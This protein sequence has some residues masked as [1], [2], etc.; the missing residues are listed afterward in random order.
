MILLASFSIQIGVFSTFG[1]LL[2]SI[3]GPFGFDTA[4]IALFG[5][6]LLASGIIC[7]PIICSIVGMT[8]RYL[9]ILRTLSC[10]LAF[11][12]WCALV[13][14]NDSN[15]SIRGFLCAIA[16]CGACAVSFLPTCIDFGIELSFPVHSTLVNGVMAM[17][18]QIAGV[19][20]G[21]VGMYLTTLSEAELK[22]EASMVKDLKQWYSMRTLV[23][24]VASTLIATILNFAI[25][26]NLKRL[27]FEKRYQNSKN[28]KN[29]DAE[30][31]EKLPLK[32][33]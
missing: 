7:A 1:S 26:E 8:K 17:S 2:G 25:E 20:F 3:F 23:F 15:N 21:S 12:F 32:E 13:L 5:A 27:N 24:L 29:K 16:I 33:Q 9:L 22:Q 19:C 31:A 28:I 14:I 6:V 11:T 4:K 30:D 18:G 10:L